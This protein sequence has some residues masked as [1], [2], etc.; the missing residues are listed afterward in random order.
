VETSHLA[1]YA[2]MVLQRIEMV[3]AQSKNAFVLK[4]SMAK[5]L[6]ESPAKDAK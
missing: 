2:P 3:Q 4:I 6:K 1:L 5:L